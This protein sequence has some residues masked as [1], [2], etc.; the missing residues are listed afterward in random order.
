[1]LDKHQVTVIC[2]MCGTLIDGWTW[3]DLFECPMCGTRMDHI[4]FDP[5][6]FYDMEDES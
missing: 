6:E 4:N 1:M 2:S 5:I 3:D